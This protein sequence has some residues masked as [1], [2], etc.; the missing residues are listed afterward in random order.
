[1][2]GRNS[3]GFRD[4]IVVLALLLVVS[5]IALIGAAVLGI[6]KGVLT[7]MGD[8]EYARGLITFLFAVVTIGTALV[9][10]VS[11]LIGAGDDMSEKQF[12][13]G[14]EVFSLLLGVF[15]TIVGYYFGATI[16]STNPLPLRIS[17]LELIPNTA[18]PGA[19]ITMRA[20]VAGGTAPYHYS[21]VGGPGDV[22]STA[23]ISD[24]GLISEQLK[25]PEH[26]VEK[27][28]QV[29]L[30]ITDARGREANISGSIDIEDHSGAHS[31]NPER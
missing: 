22:K 29:R 25:L 18:A 9:L 27:S 21:T 28:F 3:N 4:P 23:R 8:R 1:L 12:Q 6:D 7:N 15:G 31:K 20:L 16:P 14:K 26:L 24:D 2:A 10:V 19:V 11:A 17:A 30:T 5:V 13:H